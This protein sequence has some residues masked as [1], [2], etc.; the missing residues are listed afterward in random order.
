MNAI[1]CG[2]RLR[3][4]P[5][6]ERTEDL[7]AE[8]IRK[9]VGE[10]R[11]VPTRIKHSVVS[12]LHIPVRTPQTRLILDMSSSHKKRYAE[13]SPRGGFAED[14]FSNENEH[15][16]HDNDNDNEDAKLKPPPKRRKRMAR[17]YIGDEEYEVSRTFNCHICRRRSGII[18]NR[19]NNC[20]TMECSVCNEE[21]NV[22]EMCVLT[23]CGHSMCSTC[24]VKWEEVR[25]EQQ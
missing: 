9:D 25:K 3:D 1:K 8:A 11:W 15:V 12:K 20:S 2:G 5:L 14:D 18:Q 21:C 16:A 10:L 17:V 4:V 13:I 23:E 22:D 7:C 24:L 6:D 19:G